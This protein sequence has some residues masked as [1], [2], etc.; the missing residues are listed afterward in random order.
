VVNNTP[1]VLAQIALLI[2]EQDSNITKI[3]MPNEE[4]NLANMEFE[5]EVHHLDHLNDIIR[6][7]ED[8]EYVFELLR[9]GDQAA[10]G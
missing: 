6:S 4:Q 5:I 10:S 7:L 1:G 3:E 8:S 2:A 9:V